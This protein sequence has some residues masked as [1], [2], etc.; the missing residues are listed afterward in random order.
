M[1]HKD[2]F[3]MQKALQL[4]RKALTQE[5]V[6]IGALVIDEYG[7][8]IGRGYNKIEKKGS[9]LGHAEIIAIHQA[10]K[11]KKNWRLNGCWIYVTLEPCLMC[12]GLIRLSRIAGIL[13]AAPSPLFGAFSNNRALLEAA[14]KEIIL[15]QGLKESESIAMLKM[16]FMHARKKGE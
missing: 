7:E 16:F 14:E 15:M 9:Q 5:E 8:I 2:D 3:Y 11:K 1:K 10:T 6:P 4:A 12:Y 13:Y